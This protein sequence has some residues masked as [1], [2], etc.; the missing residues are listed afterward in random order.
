MKQ[1]TSFSKWVKVPLSMQVLMVV[2]TACVT[3]FWGCQ[4][5]IITSNPLVLEPK[6]SGSQLK[7]PITTQMAQSW[8][9]SKFGKSL[10]ISPRPAGVTYRSVDSLLDGQ[11]CFNESYQI[12]PIWSEAQ[13]S[14]YLRTQPILLVPVRPI[15]FLES[16]KF[17]YAL[18]FR[19]E[20]VV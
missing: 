7:N 20:G 9:E 6:E 4:K 19:S 15:A 5:D 3:L 14:S 18:V 2:L 17:Q 16:K 11:F 13:I 10:P 12:T 8:F 1:T